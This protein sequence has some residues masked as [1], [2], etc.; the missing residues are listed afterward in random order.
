MNEIPDIRLITVAKYPLSCQVRGI[1]HPHSLKRHRAWLSVLS[2]SQWAPWA[3]AQLRKSDSTLP[4][5][6][7]HLQ[8]CTTI[9]IPLPAMRA[10]DSQPPA[11]PISECHHITSL[12]LHQWKHATQTHPR[13]WTNDTAPAAL[14]WEACC[15]KVGS[16]HAICRSWMVWATFM[17]AYLHSSGLLR[18]GFV[19]WWHVCDPWWFWHPAVWLWR[20]QWPWLRSSLQNQFIKWKYYSIYCIIFSASCSKYWIT[21]FSQK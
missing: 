20:G 4:L 5:W 18:W 3:H 11:K 21:K 7:S 6:L 16:G 19:P 8:K 2:R 1:T 15:C 17:E 10:H 13:I 12:S 9:P 14:C